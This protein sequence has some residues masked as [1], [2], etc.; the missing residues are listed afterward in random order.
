MNAV[1]QVIKDVFLM[2]VNGNECFKLGSLNTSE[3]LSRN[4]NQLVQ[5]V[6]EFLIRRLHHL[7]VKPSILKC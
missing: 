6:K 2:N 7:L 3:F 1:Y 4:V 5:Y